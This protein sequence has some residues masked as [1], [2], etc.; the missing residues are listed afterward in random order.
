[1]F[2]PFPDTP[3]RTDGKAAVEE[4]FRGFFERG[5]VSLARSNR[6]VQGLAPKD[7]LVQMLGNDAAV[8]SFHLGSSPSRRS[9]VFRRA[10]ADAWKIAHWHASP[11]PVAPTAPAAAPAPAP[12]PAP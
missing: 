5:K 6:V 12:A 8:V 3:S 10:G 9:I 11:A 7:L 1:M 4:R 2:F